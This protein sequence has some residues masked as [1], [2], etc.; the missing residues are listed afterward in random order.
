MGGIGQVTAGEE[1]P[2]RKDT[3]ADL[4]DADPRPGVEGRAEQVIICRDIAKRLIEAGQVGLPATLALQSQIVAVGKLS[5]GNEARACLGANRRL[6]R[7]HAKLRAE[8]RDRGE[9]GRL[10]GVGVIA[11]ADKDAAGKNRARAPVSAC[12][13]SSRA[14]SATSGGMEG[15]ASACSA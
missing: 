10:I 2:Q 11:T 8:H 9:R 1:G 13:R 6:Y 3:I 4:A 12:A 14:R 5:V 15:E 7:N